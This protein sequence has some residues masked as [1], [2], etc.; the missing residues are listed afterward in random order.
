[1]RKAEKFT[2]PSSAQRA[3]GADYIPSYHG[4][5]GPVNIAFA[6]KMYGGPQQGDFSN[7]VTKFGVTKSKDLNGGAPNCVSFTPNVSSFT[8]FSLSFPFYVWL[9]PSSTFSNLSQ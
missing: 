9:K 1:M 6:Q 7:T 2:A 8:S 5:S 3:K 4:S